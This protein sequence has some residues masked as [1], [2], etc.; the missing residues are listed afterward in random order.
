MHYGPN[1]PLG[2]TQDHLKSLMTPNEW[3][4][5]KFFMNG[6]TIG[7]EDEIPVYYYGDVNRFCRYHNTE[8]KP[9]PTELLEQ[10]KHDRPQVAAAIEK[11]R[12]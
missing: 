4:N 10:L 3:L 6:Q 5:F 2:Y 1:H 11:A 8:L 7:M 9:Q 12:Q